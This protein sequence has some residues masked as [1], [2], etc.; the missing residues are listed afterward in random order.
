MKVRYYG[1]SCFGIEVGGKHLLFDPFISG[2]PLAKAIKIDEI[3]C[4]F[5]LISHGHLDH[6]LDAEAIAKRTNCLVIGSYEVMDWLEKK[7]LKNTHKMNTG[8][9]W[10]FDFGYVKCVNA[11]HSS[12]MPD[13]TYGGNPMGFVIES[14]DGVFYFAG[15]TAL[16]LD[17]QLIPMICDQLDFAILPIGSNFTMDYRD[18]IVASDF[19]QCSTIIGCHYDT[20]DLIK[21]DHAEAQSAFVEEEKELILLEI[22]EDLEFE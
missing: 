17:M 14:E 3:P 21:I 10:Q 4:D 8:G 9:G 5:M 18:A 13:G 6:I 11:I 12:V 16:T 7:G 20:F 22:G 1:Q 19:I 2:N 15:D